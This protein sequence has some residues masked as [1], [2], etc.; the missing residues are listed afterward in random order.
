MIDFIIEILL[1]L[2][3]EGSVELGTNRK[4]PM[5][6]RIVALTILIAGSGGLFL[7]LLWM[8]V[9][10]MKARSIVLGGMILLLDLILL[11]SMLHGFRKRLRVNTRQITKENDE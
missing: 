11:A 10:I 3:F 7:L 1:E 9:N 4:I 6:L 5:P 8:A 2:I